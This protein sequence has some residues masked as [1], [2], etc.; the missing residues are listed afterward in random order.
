M[1]PK[2]KK[3]LVAKRKTN[4]TQANL[5]QSLPTQILPIIFGM[6]VKDKQAKQKWVAYCDAVDF[7]VSQ[8]NCW[9]V[10]EAFF[11]QRIL[12]L[13]DYLALWAA[14][15]ASS[16]NDVKKLVRQSPG[17]NVMGP[18]VAKVK[19]KEDV[20]SIL[21]KLKAEMEANSFDNLYP[22]FMAHQKVKSVMLS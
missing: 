15:K 6:V 16:S 8:P 4:T 9:G 22:T 5:L 21:R 13:D 10:A 12:T 17:W 19:T 2:A 18:I 1:A 20:T 14:S 7:F 3:A 11:V